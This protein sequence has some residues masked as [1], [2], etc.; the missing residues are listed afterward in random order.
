VCAGQLVRA[1]QIE[2]LIGRIFFCS[3][4]VGLEQLSAYD[5]AVKLPQDATFDDADKAY[6]AKWMD[7]NCNQTDPRSHFANQSTL[8]QTFELT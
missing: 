3:W 2:L 1:S 7:E 6:S 4:G 8:P 5:A